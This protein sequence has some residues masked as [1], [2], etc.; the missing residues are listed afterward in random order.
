[1]LNIFNSLKKFFLFNYVL[2]FKIKLT[3][4]PVYVLIS[5]QQKQNGRKRAAHRR[6][7]HNTAQQKK[8]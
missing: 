6:K 8:T 2:T 1:M 5:S 3:F 7:K 4:F